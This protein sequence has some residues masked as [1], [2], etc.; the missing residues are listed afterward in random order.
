MG[1][2]PVGHAITRRTGGGPGEP[3]GEPWPGGPLDRGVLVDENRERELG[4]DRRE[5]G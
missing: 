2:P 4:L 3:P 5:T 1:A